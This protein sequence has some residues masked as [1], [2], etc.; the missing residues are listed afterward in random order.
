M[1]PSNYDET[2]IVQAVQR[3]D[4]PRRL[5]AAHEGRHDAEI[6]GTIVD[7]GVGAL[8]AVPKVVGIDEVGSWATVDEVVAVVAAE[9]V[10][11]EI[12]ME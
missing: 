2:L 5:E 10:V 4:L 8:E 1:G 6:V 7:N 9:L 11:S 3:W 12:A